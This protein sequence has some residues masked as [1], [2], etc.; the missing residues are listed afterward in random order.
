MLRFFCAGF[1]S[2]LQCKLCLHTH[3]CKQNPKILSNFHSMKLTL[4]LFNKLGSN[5]WISHHKY[6]NEL[7]YTYRLRC[8]NFT[9]QYLFYKAKQNKLQHV[10]LQFYCYNKSTY[11]TIQIITEKQ[12]AKPP[13]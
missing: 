8:R 7:K 9:S 4:V 2:L 10:N 11:S 3:R 5:C 13:S 1:K 6:F 12:Y